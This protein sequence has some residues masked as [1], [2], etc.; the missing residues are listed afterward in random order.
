MLKFTIRFSKLQV[1]GEIKIVSKSMIMSTKS[2]ALAD[3]SSTNPT[4]IESEMCRL[5]KDFAVVKVLE[6]GNVILDSLLE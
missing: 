1:K 4:F 6:N 2:K 3:Q 5:T